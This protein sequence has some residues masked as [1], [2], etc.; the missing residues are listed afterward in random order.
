MI[1]V[2]AGV[3]WREVDLSTYIPRLS[4]TTVAMVGTA[5]KGPTN[6]P[7]FVSNIGAFTSIFGDPNP[8]HLSM[9]S[10]LEFLRWGSQLWFVRVNGSSSSFA[11][12]NLSGAI[13]KASV[14]STIKGPYVFSNS[15]GPVVLGTD[16]GSTVSTIDSSNN[17]LLISVN[18]SSPVVV[19][20][21]PGTD[22]TKTS[23]A[24]AIDTALAPYGASAAVAGTNQ[25]QLTLDS[26]QGSSTSIAI[27]S[28][29]NNAYTILGL[30]VGTTYGTNDD[31]QMKVVLTSSGVDT[32]YAMTFTTGSRTTDQ[33]VTALNSVL[34]GY[35]TA[36]NIDGYVKIV[37]D[38]LGQTHA[39]SF[40]R[41]SANAYDTGA[42]SV[43]GFTEGVLTYGRGT[44][45]SST[46][47]V[48]SA[49]SEG[50]WGNNLTI[51]VTNGSV[52][53]T[54]KLQVKN[55]GVLVEQFNNLIGTAGQENRD[56]GIKYFLSAINGV[57]KY[58]TVEDTIENTGFPEV[59]SFVLS[60]GDDG[61]ETISDD[62]YIGTISGTVKTG[63]QIFSNAE[64]IDIN[65]MLCPGVHSA[66]V[67]NEMISLC[68]DRGDC[69]AIVDPPLGLSVQQVVDWHNGATTYSDHAAFNSS[70]AALYW[71][72]TQ[73]FDARNDRYLWVPPS[74]H[75]ASIY[76]Y[77]D[78]VSEPWFAPAGFNRGRLLT[79]NKLEHSPDQGERDYLYGN[80]NAVNPIVK[81]QKDGIAIW[82]QRTL[83]RKPSALDRVNVRRLML[84]I[85]KVV[86]TAVRY[87]VFEPN[88]PVTWRT[89]SA[90]VDPFMRGLVARRGVV[91]YQIVCDET[92][93]TPDHINNNEMVA[94]IYIEPVKAAEKIL[95]D[96]V[97]TPS[98]ANF[99]EVVY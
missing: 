4:T 95:V 71:P 81:F 1:Y 53:D 50:A 2:S 92:T 61:L 48:V 67:I 33:V 70:Y 69:M 11:T 98:G 62:D 26:G 41:S 36:Y 79:V 34:V 56:L 66:A 20:L 35:A 77:S 88:D 59:G 16:Q 43:L 23:I 73:I 29:A 21:T 65:L 15:S 46:T 27:H 96:A 80:Q 31:N 83:Q 87:L 60:G 3:Y 6:T 57:S 17:K 8:N 42:A 28:I 22:V 75:A 76:A 89:F 49:I 12:K 72:W 45:P 63:L 19:T 5:P 32:E 86:S 39:I 54:F 18:G 93:N 55:N 25:I 40:A 58:I 38:S 85:R 37:H 90:M 68:T 24:T 9:Y 47:M 99:D 91:K 30:T 7:I 94:R 97:L 84:Y 14:V 10:A 64:E 52:A 13:T 44:S 78:E 51:F 74:G 82:G